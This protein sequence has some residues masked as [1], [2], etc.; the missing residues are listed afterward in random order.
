M[1]GSSHLYAYK[2]DAR[3]EEIFE[4]HGVSAYSRKFAFGRMDFCGLTTIPPDH[5]LASMER[6]DMKGKIIVLGIDVTKSDQWM[7]L[8]PR[9]KRRKANAKRAYITQR[10]F[11]QITD[12]IRPNIHSVIGGMGAGSDLTSQLRRLGVH[13]GARDIPR[14]RNKSGKSFAQMSKRWDKKY[15]R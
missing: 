11:S 2:Q 12:L 6:V 3:I 15:K 14:P 10:E 8:Q 9:I 7:K 1:F 13:I 5:R 4:G